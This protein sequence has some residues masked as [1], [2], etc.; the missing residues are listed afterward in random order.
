MTWNSFFDTF[1]AVGDWD[2]IVS[3]HYVAQLLARV[4]IDR[5]TT[6]LDYGCGGGYDV[7]VLGSKAGHVFGTDRSPSQ[8]ARARQRTHP[9]SNCSIVEYDRYAS[10]PPLDLILC[11]SVIQYMSPEELQ[12]ELSVW[13]QLLKDDG[14]VVC[15][16]VLMER[17]HFVAEVMEMFHLARSTSSLA[18]FL[19]QVVR[20]VFSPYMLMQHRQPLATYSF[21]LLVGLGNDVGFRVAVSENLVYNRLRKTVT[22]VKVS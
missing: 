9:L 22:F 14:T 18:V 7:R 10:L 17:P 1:A 2:Q 11:K 16:D 3:D 8:L 21:E 19:R 13:H 15:A 5:T 6:V 4:P 20:Q 12:R